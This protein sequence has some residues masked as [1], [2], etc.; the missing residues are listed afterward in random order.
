M[1]IAFTWLKLDLVILVLTKQEL[2]N[3]LD[4][5]ELIPE[6]AQHIP[7]QLRSTY[8]H[9]LLIFRLAH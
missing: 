2:L 7:T 4:K 5:N 6:T 3:E 1:Q 8:H 9:V